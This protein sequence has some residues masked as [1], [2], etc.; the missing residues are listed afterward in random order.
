MKKFFMGICIQIRYQRVTD[1]IRRRPAQSLLPLSRFPACIT[2]VTFG[3]ARGL[4]FND[5]RN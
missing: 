2:P 5:P 1:S 3:F 4:V